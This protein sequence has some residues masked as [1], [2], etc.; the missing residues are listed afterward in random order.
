MFCPVCKKQEQV[1][2][3]LR[4]DQFAEEIYE[5]RICG[6]T[7][8]VNHG[9]VEIITDPQHDSFLEKQTEAVESDDYNLSS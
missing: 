5:C 7:W 3:K 1:E 6:T 8:S 9:T 4:S 2:I